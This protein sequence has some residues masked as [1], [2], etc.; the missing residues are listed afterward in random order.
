MSSFPNVLSRSSAAPTL[1][2]NFRLAEPQR[3]NQ[4]IELNDI[5]MDILG[6]IRKLQDN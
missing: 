3:R 4:K 5:I 6:L 1:L 2:V